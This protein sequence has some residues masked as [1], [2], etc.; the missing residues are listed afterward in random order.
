[1]ELTRHEA[2][3]RSLD[4][5]RRMCG[6]PR[7]RDS[8]LDRPVPRCAAPERDRVPRARRHRDRRVPRAIDEGAPLMRTIVGVGA[9]APAAVA[10]RVFVEIILDPTSHN[11]WPFEIVIAAATGFACAAA[12][13]PRR[14][15][16]QE[17]LAAARRAASQRNAF[18]AK[19]TPTKQTPTSGAPRRRR[20]GSSRRGSTP[21]GSYPTFRHCWDPRLPRGGRAASGSCGSFPSLRARPTSARARRAP[22]PTKR[23][24]A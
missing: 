6:V 24:R 13:A 2:P 17:N 23:Y 21:A 18:P 16:F 8:L 12:G 5:D 3:H 19:Q 22:P 10:V 9:S 20:R 15:R 4:C 11:L 14:V 7:D 1:M